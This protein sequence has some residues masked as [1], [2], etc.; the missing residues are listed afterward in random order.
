MELLE[1]RFSGIVVIIGFIVV[2]FFYGFKVYLYITYY[3]VFKKKL[4]FLEFIFI[5]KIVLNFVLFIIYYLIF[6][7]VGEGFKFLRYY[8]CFCINVMNEIFFIFSFY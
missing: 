5:K 7:R 6:Y 2:Y 4:F 1:I 3:C 8:D